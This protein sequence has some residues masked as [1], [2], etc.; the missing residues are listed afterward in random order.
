MDE[1]TALPTLEIFT[2]LMARVDALEREV[3]R[4]QAENVALRAENELLRAEN[5][6]L[7]AEVNRLTLELAAARK[8]SRNS[9]KP[10]SSDI[11]KPKPPLPEGQTKR[12]IGGQPGHAPH[13]RQPFTP[14]QLDESHVFDP[15]SMTCSCGGRLEACPSEDLVQQQIDLPEQP[16]IRREY[17][18]RAYRCSSCGARRRG[19]LPRREGYVG[20]RLAAV[21]GF[22]NAKAHASHTVIADFTKDVLGEPV[23]RGQ[24]AK[25]FGRVS[26]ALKASYQ[27]A[28]ECLRGEPVLHIDETGHREGGKRYWTRVFRGGDFTVFHIDKTRSAAV[29][30][31]ILGPGFKGVIICDYYSSY[32]KYLKGVD[33]RAQ[34]CLAH[35]I[36]DLRFLEGHPNPEV[37][38]YAEHSLE[39]MRRMFEVH[40][41]LRENPE[42]DRKELVL[43]GEK[44]RKAM[45]EAPA[46]PKAQNLAKRFRDNGD[47]YLRFITHLNVEPTNNNGEQS[48]RHVVIDR[49]SSQGTRS[50]LGRD[51]KARIWSAIATCAQRGTSAFHHLHNAL[52]TY[53]NPS[54]S[55]P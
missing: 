38:H 16:V 40:H 51:Y 9:S 28:L 30:E 18:A 50:P 2:A 34:F 24:I 10:P 31:S 54:A 44:L 19:K 20:N 13:F 15:P 33:A 14:E 7:K 23:S 43:A 39:A 6:A 25:T 1:T 45:L 17:R 49:A 46:E 52:K 42:H 8:N 11:V 21:W 29:L 4:L 5:E 37:K 47:S 32:H 22:L 12:R 26:D 27:E 35:L 53:A 36:R 41:R 3:A 48:I 55:P